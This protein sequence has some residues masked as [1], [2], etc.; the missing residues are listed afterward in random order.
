MDIFFEGPIFISTFFVYSDDF[1]AFQK[2]F[3]FAPSAIINFLVAS[4]KLLTIF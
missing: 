4:L 2:L 3:N 1:Q